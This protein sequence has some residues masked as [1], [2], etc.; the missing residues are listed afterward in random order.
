MYKFLYV[1]ILF[2][3]QALSAQSDCQDAIIVCGSNNYTGLTAEGIGSIQELDSLTNPCRSRENNSI[4][5]KILIKDGGTLGLMLTPESS[6]LVVD[7]DFW[8]YGPNA[9]CSNLGSA[10]RC[11]T[12]NPLAAFLDTNI[13]GMVD[14]ETDFFEGPAEDGT[15]FINWMDVQDDEIYYLIIDRPV[16]VANFDLTWTG[17]ATFHDTPYF[18]NADNISLD[19]RQCDDDSVDDKTTIFDLSTHATMLIGN[20]TDVVLSYHHN[21]N[22]VTNNI[23]A[24]PNATL[25]INT[26]IQETIYMRLTNPDTGCF[27]V[28]TF[29]IEV[30]SV[31]DT[32]EPDDLYLCDL[33]ENGYQMFS[34]FLN[35][36]LIKD[37]NP[38]RSVVYYGSQQNAEN[39]T[40]PLG[41][42][43]QNTV[44]YLTE[45]IWARMENTHGC[46]GYGL[47]SFT[48]TTIPL[49]EV[50]YTLDVIDFTAGGNSVFINIQNQP[51][52]EYSLDGMLYTDNPYFTNLEPGLYTIFIRS[53]DNCRT[54]TED[55]LILNYP[56]FFTPNGDGIN[57]FWTLPYLFMQPDAS[58]EIYD[59]YGKLITGFKGSNEGW[60]GTYNGHALP[61]TDYWFKL[62]LKNERIIKGHFALI[63]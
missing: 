32:G 2:T 33:H 41:L 9:S 57:E 48:I 15:A 13:T 37:G 39:E 5:F 18:D 8:I 14:T 54:V 31:L 10:I 63:R 35:T 29:D 17:T 6:N 28:E 60:D 55:I 7:F 49:P 27:A 56:K 19:L 52:F 24:E 22:D 44:P 59:R 11:S 1:I 36:D 26:A 43:H 38:D 12:T 47:T 61:S 50:N 51:N 23:N 45:T 20:Q 34:L 42:V 30:V 62:E 21:L 3:S 58:I 53:K 25:Y 16:G 4:W 40:G 46:F